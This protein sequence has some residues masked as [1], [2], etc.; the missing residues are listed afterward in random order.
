[1]VELIVVIG[2]IAILAGLLLPAVNHMRRSALITGE[3][4]DFQTIAS[5][6]EQYKA[7][8]GDYPRNSQLPTWS[9][10][11]GSYPAMMYFT[12][13]T[14]LLGPGPAVTG[15]TGLGDGNDGPGFRSQETNIVSGYASIM[16]GTTML[17]FT[18]DANM[19]TQYAT[20]TNNFVSST[21]TPASITLLP[22]TSS[23]GLNGET[24]GIS[25]LTPQQQTLTIAAYTH[26]MVRAILF[27]PGGKVWGPYISADTFKTV[28]F[29]STQNPPTSLAPNVGQAL[30][31]QPLLLD[32]WGQVIQYFPRYGPASNRTNDSSLYPTNLDKSV[33]AGPLIGYSQPKSVDSNYGQN[34]IWDLRDGAP[35]YNNVNGTPTQAFF[36]VTTAGSEFDPTTAIDWM[37]GNSTPN[38]TGNGFTNVIKAPDKLNYDGPYILISAGPDGPTRANGGYCSMIDVN[39]NLLPANQWQQQMIASGNIYN[40]DHP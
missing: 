27:V 8:F 11:N 6:L 36:P 13:A 21:A 37:L 17:Q 2:I 23:S 1:M 3:K 26:N 12:L 24:L 39:G 16:Q 34:A 31:G 9:T 38:G 4:A 33:Q 18:A 35:F 28:V 19:A 32:R 5:A 14:A 20:F 25:T 29:S 40:F 7:D 10:Q 22:G 15:A 30:G